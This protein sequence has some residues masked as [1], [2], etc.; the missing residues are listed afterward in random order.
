M[1]TNNGIT[2][3]DYGYVV[4]LQLKTFICVVPIILQIYGH[5]VFRVICTG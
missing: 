3:Y 5:S 2:F 4:H 1:T